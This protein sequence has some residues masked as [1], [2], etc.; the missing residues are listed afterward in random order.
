MLGSRTGTG[1][2]VTFPPLAELLPH[3][4]PMILLDSVAAFEPGRVVC[5]VCPR[6]DSVFARQGSLPAIVVLEYMAQATAVLT[7]LTVEGP[8]PGASPGML[9]GVRGLRLARAKLEF[10]AAL[11]V[12]AEVQTFSARGGVFECRVELEGETIA[13]ARL[14]V[15]TSPHSVVER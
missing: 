12:Q 11:T 8:S 2:R 7:A 1:Y 4:S 9:V 13:A 5:R 15:V 6:A 10:D 14:T 3:R